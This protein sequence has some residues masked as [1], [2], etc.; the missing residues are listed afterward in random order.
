[1]HEDG[2]ICLADF[3]LAR[4]LTEDEQATSVVGTLEYCAPEVLQYDPNYSYE[5]DWWALGILAYE[6]ALGG[7]PFVPRYDRGHPRY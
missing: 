3:G 2:Y 6:M 5:V 7:S 1:M 4:I